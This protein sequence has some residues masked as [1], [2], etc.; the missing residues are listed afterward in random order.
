MNDDLLCS[1]CGDELSV[2]QCLTSACFNT[3]CETCEQ[4]TGDGSGYCSGCVAAGCGRSFSPPTSGIGMDIAGII[5]DMYND[6]ADK[7]F[8]SL[9]GVDTEALASLAMIGQMPAAP[10]SMKKLVTPIDAPIGDG[11]KMSAPVSC[12]A[13]PVMPVM[14]LPMRKRGREDADTAEAAPAPAPAP[15]HGKQ[16][17]KQD[18]APAALTVPRSR[19][20]ASHP[21]LPQCVLDVLHAG[22]VW[23]S[24]KPYV[25]RHPPTLVDKML[26][27]HTSTSDLSL[28]LQAEEYCEILGLV[29]PVSELRDIVLTFRG[30]TVREFPGLP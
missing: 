20:L 15:A 9:G 27:P 16:R 7:H 5:M 10:P 3:T 17:P 8:V 24:T 4:F 11:D 21:H 22:D 30:V 14:P 23:A 1:F 6:N 25:A 28:Y 18:A 26:R 12:A 29:R 19:Y 13:V 2:Y